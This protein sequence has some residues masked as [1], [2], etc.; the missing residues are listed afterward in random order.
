M[1]IV[2]LEDEEP[3]A[4]RLIKLLKDYDE[5]I[6]ITTVIV[7]IKTAIKWFTENKVPNLI[8]SDIQL[9]DGLCFEIF[10]AVELHCP[11]IFTTAYNEFAIDAFKVN[12]IDYLLK[13]IK[14]EALA[15]AL[16]KYN[17]IYTVRE[18]YFEN[19]KKTVHDLNMPIKSKYKN[20]FIVRFGDQI[21]T[22]NVKEI[23]FF[24]TEL[25]TNF[26]VTTDAK[27]YI[28]DNN[29]DAISELVD[30]TSYFRINRQFIISIASIS[31]MYKHTKSR[32]IIHLQPIT[33]QPTVVSAERSKEFKKWLD[34]NK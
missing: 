31:K 33:K 12:S 15:V 32:V 23:A 25:K 30:P 13:P 16:N 20:R 8:I 5:D 4:N 17:K 24:Y 7:S 34:D 2:I 29:L 11:I 14:K 18:Q 6:I 10:N 27:K 9:A 22:I 26:L 3:A 1:Q 28:I 19:I 21:K